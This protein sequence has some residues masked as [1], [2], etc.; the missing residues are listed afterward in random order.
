M[1]KETNTKTEAEVKQAT[2]EQLDAA[3]AKAI[4]Y[5]KQQ[6]EVLALQVNYEKHLAEIETH[7][8]TRM[9]M[10]LRQ[11]HMA[12]PAPEQSEESEDTKAPIAPVAP[13]DRKLKTV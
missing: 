6:G 5:Y 9:E 2:P 11:A 12:N 1:S 7:R 13:K 8:A 3:R 10:I 4:K